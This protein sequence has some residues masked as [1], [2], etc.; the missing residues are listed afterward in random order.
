[1][2]DLV[3]QSLPLV[4]AV[5][6]AAA[7]FS[8]GLDLTTR[9][10][11]EPLRNGRLVAWSLLASI[12]LVPLAALGIASVIPLDE[13][14]RIGFVLY[15]LA[16]GAESGPKFVQQARGNA[17]FAVGLL[18]LQIVIA[19][20]CV[21]I[22]ITFVAP[23]AHV[24][25]GA[26]LAKLLIVVALPLGIGLYVKARSG[27]LAARLY[28]VAHRAWAILFVIAFAQLVYVYHGE[29][30]EID[31]NALVAALLL[32]A[33]AFAAGYL[34]GGPER[35]DRRALAIMTLPRNT[36]IALMIAGQV[37]ANVAGVL[38][39]ITTLTILAIAITVA[40]AAGLRRLPV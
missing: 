14:L 24:A 39:M 10:I 31:A 6:L 28:V 29:V 8:L 21:P 5:F 25:R 20:V 27:A 15:A 18:A 36:G 33:A 30:L 11:V 35:A 12:V 23:D 2:H 13:G 17:A 32:F 16:A 4:I 22:A 1:M 3:V 38:V 26:L 34:L 9:Q 40:T 19:V 37:F 7:M